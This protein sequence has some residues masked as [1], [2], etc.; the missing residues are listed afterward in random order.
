MAIGCI[1]AI[2]E[3]GLH[4]PDHISVVGFDDV[5]LASFTNPPLTTIAQ[6]KREIGQ[7]AMDLL[8]GRIQDLDTPPQFNRLDTTLVV[9][10]ST[11]QLAENGLKE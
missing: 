3:Q 5:K 4:I 2:T 1:S 10:R 6:P 7:L 9:R 8:L 11:S